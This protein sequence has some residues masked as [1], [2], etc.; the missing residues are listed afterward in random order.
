MT[1]LQKPK[2][3]IT[4]YCDLTD[5]EYKIA[6]M[7]KLNELQEKS[8]RQFNELRNKTN[9]QRE[10]FTKEIQTLKNNQTEIVKQK[11]SINE[12]KSSIENIGN[13]ADHMG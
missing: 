7:K 2:L 1:I 6:V 9:N 10:K 8:E 12:M 4:E 3:K 5:T 11:D 13:R